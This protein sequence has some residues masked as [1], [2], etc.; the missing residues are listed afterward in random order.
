VSNVDQLIDWFRDP[1]HWAG[2]EGVP[3]RVTEHISISFTAVAI[4]ILIALPIGLA[5]GHTGRGRFLAVSVANLGRAIPSFAI[6]S[7]TFQLVLSFAPEV[8]FGFVP[9][10][11][12][13]TLLAIPP[14][15]TNSYVGVEEVDADI[16]E[17]ARGMGMSGVQVLRRLEVPLAVPFILAGI[18]TAAVQ[19]VAT[20]TLAALIAGGGLGRYIIDGFAQGDEGMLLAGAV[21]VAILA[22][23]T[24]VLFAGIQRAVT[25]RVSSG[26]GRRRR[27]S[28][29]ELSPPPPPGWPVGAGVDVSSGNG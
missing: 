27:E 9:T 17:A 1:E 8:A 3:A 22:I 24:E 15:L 23:L 29:A 11:V 6:L 25:P 26:S 7:I 2:P 14:I 28:F 16:V 10:V 12:A 5:I 19:V 18:R 20:A 21:L 4:A 13:L